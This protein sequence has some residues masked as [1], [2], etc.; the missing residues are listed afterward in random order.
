[1]LLQANLRV[2]GLIQHLT[3]HAARLPCYKH[4]MLVTLQ[5][6]VSADVVH[7]E[8]YL[9]NTFTTQAHFST[10]C[11][12]LAHR[13]WQDQVYSVTRRGINPQNNP[14][15]QIEHKE[16]HA[17]RRNTERD[18][19]L[20]LETLLVAQLQGSGYRKPYRV[21]P[22]TPNP[23]LCPG[24]KH[25]AFWPHVARKQG[26]RA[27]LWKVSDEIPILLPQRLQQSTMLIA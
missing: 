7:H 3:C 25:G 13:V 8:S 10:C 18:T 26:F 16:H 4:H 15:Y 11:L 2:I 12:Q 5:Q 21:K 19:T 1:M 14:E 23:A 9:R 22:W 6:K 27:E 17:C 20:L 24:N